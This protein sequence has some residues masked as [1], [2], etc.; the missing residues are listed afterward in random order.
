MSFTKIANGTSLKRGYERLTM[1]LMLGNVS[2]IYMTTVRPRGIS[3]A[4][5]LEGFDFALMI[6][7]FNCILK[8]IKSVFLS[9]YRHTN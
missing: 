2:C 9:A 7:S 8:L 3:L 6:N 4:D 1:L 5:L